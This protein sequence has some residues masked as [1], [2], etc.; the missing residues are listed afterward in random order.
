MIEDTG[1]MGCL[2]FDQFK[3]F[4]QSC[5]RKPKYAKTSRCGRAGKKNLRNPRQNGSLA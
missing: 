2:K 4:E 1:K 5:A 3:N